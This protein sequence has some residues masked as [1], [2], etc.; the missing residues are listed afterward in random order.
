[1]LHCVMFDLCLH[2]ALFANYSVG[3]LRTKMG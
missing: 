3:G 1:M 2:S